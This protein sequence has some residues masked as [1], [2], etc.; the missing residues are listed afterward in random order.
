MPSGSLLDM[1]GMVRNIVG[2][3]NLE[4]TRRR[5]DIYEQNSLLQ[6]EQNKIDQQKL[7]QTTAFR[8]FDELGK[9]ADHPALATNLDK[10]ADLLLM[11]GKVM[12]TGLGVKVPLPSKDELMGGFAQTKT[13]MHAMRSGN[14][15]E[16]QGAL[17]EAMTANPKWA[18]TV[19][20]DMKKGG[21][22]TA[23]MQE[24]DVKLQTHQAQLE[25]INLKNGKLK[26]QEGLFAE[27]AAGLTRVANL[28]GD[29]KFAR[30]FQEILSF[31]K[32]EARQAY[33][34]LPENQAFKQAFEQ[35]LDAERKDMGFFDGLGKEAEGMTP[36]K[37][38]LLEQ[39]VEARAKALA[40]AQ[41]KSPDGQA[42]E[43]Q[44]NELRSY[45]VIRKA[46]AVEAEW[47]KDPYNKDKW[48]SL[49]K[50]EQDLRLEQGTT[51]KK[52]TELADQ[53]TA[54]AQAKFDQKTQTG[55]AERDL[56]EEF[57]R[58]IKAGKNDSQALGDAIG[59]VKQKY[60]GVPFDAT[61]VTNP[62]KRHTQ[63][64]T[65]LSP[66]ERTN[67]AEERTL[68]GQ[69]DKIIANF[70]PSYV[71]MWDSRVGDV[72]QMT[73]TL[74]AKREMWLQESRAFVAEAR[75]KIF[76]AS[77]TGSEKEAAL[78]E[79]P[80]ERM[81]DKQWPAAAKAWRDKWGALIE[82]RLR[83]AGQSRTPNGQP[84][85]PQVDLRGMS[86]QELLGVILQGGQP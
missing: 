38:Y 35:R 11:Q 85:K 69:L 76:G 3:Q 51:T 45:E 23:Q 12:E 2:M 50:A 68:V 58:G 4:E 71:G 57:L 39:E 70:D 80:N 47:L 86:E 42:P 27:H 65:L 79:L 16:A 72:G 7:R 29:P 53:R 22:L 48:K 73:S 77:L 46:R 20:D 44:L 62:D 24:L 5:N 37:V 1:D 84:A 40:D 54:L 30:Q 18:R 15:A 28:A 41:A 81:G 34:N 55:L 8:A 9:M 19:L 49:K 13:L 43:D 36:Q 25:A 59:S 10:Q 17:M 83:V 75:H 31:Q 32:P 21:E 66:T 52:L 67:I 82:Q 60:P 33:L 63:T 14:Q 6:A 64:V 61:K 78:S 56:T 26:I 74:S